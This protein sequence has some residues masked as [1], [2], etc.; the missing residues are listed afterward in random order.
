M[1]AVSSPAPARPRNVSRASTPRPARL[2]ASS[3]AAMSVTARP[4]S[5]RSRSA[6]PVV[7]GRVGAVELKQKVGLPRGAAQRVQNDA[8]RRLQAA[9]PIGKRAWRSDSSG[10]KPEVST[11][12]AS[13]SPANPRSWAMAMALMI[14]RL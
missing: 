8:L 3:S 2:A 14:S 13:R 1:A 5:A 12:S 7:L 4:P 10:A 11:A 6:P 9:V